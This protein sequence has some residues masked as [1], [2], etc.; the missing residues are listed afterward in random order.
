MD[1]GIEPLSSRPRF[2]GIPLDTLTMD[3][4]LGRLDEF[5]ES[6]NGHHIATVNLDFIVRAQRDMWLRA[7]LNRTAMNLVDGTPL[8][9]ALRALGCPVPERVAGADI[10]PQLLARLAKTGRAVYLLGGRP[11]VAR[12]AARRMLSRYEGLR[13][14]GVDTPSE[15]AVELMEGVTARRVAAAAP[16]V[17]FVAFGNPK[18]E[19]WLDLHLAELN[20]PIAIGIG[21]TVDFLAGSRRRAP[22]WM[23]HAGLEWL[24]RLA[25]EPVRLGPRYARDLVT[26]A[27][28]LTRE[29]IAKGAIHG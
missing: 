9:W 16:A 11:E 20:I 19:Y 27:R 10:V 3:A 25:Q 2:G 14:C 18:Q 1:Q 12:E 26:F 8:L 15:R 13:I 5:L 7:I 24:A 21:G 6:S 28:L 17:L 22:R 23:R 4:T 29:R